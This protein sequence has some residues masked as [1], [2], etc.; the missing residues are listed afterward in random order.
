[1]FIILY[2]KHYIWGFLSLY[3]YSNATISAPYW[4]ITDL[5]IV[6][7]R[8]QNLGFHRNLWCIH[9]FKKKRKKSK[10]GEK[11][12]VWG[13]H[14]PCPPTSILI[15]QICHKSFYKCPVGGFSVGWKYPIQPVSSPAGLKPRLLARLSV[16]TVSDPLAICRVGR[17]L[18]G[19]GRGQ[20]EGE[21]AGVVL[22]N[23]RRFYNKKN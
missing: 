10:G 11:T 16:L 18:G 14:P 9:E 20:G 15:K 13:Y 22:S 12:P 17:P 5:S 3:C 21:G 1:M 19:G 23:F 2:D 7:E 4:S 6:T 8:K